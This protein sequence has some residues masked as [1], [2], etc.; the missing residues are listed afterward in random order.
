[1]RAAAR[2]GL[3]LWTLYMLSFGGGPHSP[4]EIG[5]LGTTASLVRRGSFDANEL[6]WMIPAAGDRSDAQVE[7]GPSGDVWSVRGPTVPLQMAPWHALALWLPWLDV[8]FTTLLSSSLVTAATG[9]LLVLLGRRAGLSE[10]AAIAG[11]A[12]F[13]VASMAWP[14]A[15]LG[16]GEPAIGLLTVAAALVAPLGPLG[17]AGAG[18]A[19]AG[20]AGAKWSAAALAAPIGLYVV[21][22]RRSWRGAVAFAAGFGIG[23]AA[24]AW[25]NLARFGSALST[26]YEL[27]GREQF[28]T[29]PW[30]GLLGLT[31]SP[32]R[33]LIWFWP[34]AVA[35]ALALPAAWRRAPWLVALAVAVLGVTVATFAGWRMWWGGNAWGPR[36]LVPAL[37]LLALVLPL[38]WSGLGRAARV[39]A[40]GLVAASAL[41]QVPGVLF[42]FN[43]FER[44][45]RGPLPDFP[46]AGGL[47]DARA[48]QI[49][50]QARRLVDGWPCSVDL[51]WVKCGAVDWALAA[52]LVGALALAGMALGG[53]PPA[54][55]GRG[56]VAPHPG[57]RPH[58]S[59]LPTGEGTQAGR[60][61]RF[62]A[63]TRSRGARG[64]LDAVAGLGAV[65]ALALLLGRGPAAPGGSMAELLEAA[66]AR[67]AAARPGDG[68]IVLAS[69]AVPA[70]W[71]RDRWRGAVYGLNRDDVPRL[72]EAERMLTLAA[73]RHARL[74]LI[75]ADVPRDEA[76]NGVDRW[77]DGHAFPVEER[78]IGAARLRLL[79]TGPTERRAPAPSE[80]L[81]RFAGEGVELAGA[82]LLDDRVSARDPARVELAWRLAPG[83]AEGVSVFVHLYADGRLVGQADAPLARSLPHGAAAATY[84][85]VGYGRYA[86]RLAEGAAG[87]LSLEV[88]LYRAATGERLAALR[89]ER[90]RFEADRVPV[91]RLSA[92]AGRRARRR[93][94]APSRRARARPR[95]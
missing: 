18:L 46:R 41:V 20:A 95:R 29:D 84:R 47:L 85:G 5:Q 10:R 77:L 63:S 60:D 19:V 76:L 87:E 86:P 82:W 3:L 58:P 39:A 67:D 1:V 6:F 78:A 36:F 56:V 90:A 68:L 34:A 15:R 7:I 42:D 30:Y 32:Y 23:M 88:G 45:L 72:P 52:A 65:G 57:G 9:A 79:L 89:P 50:D 28:S 61:V 11:G 26:G 74:W 70:L 14:Y 55:G 51:V 33:G 83:A 75:A 93:P 40:A 24:L 21:L 91:G 25:H 49:V 69:P 31:L 8:T 37:P 43:V 94:G 71:S 12:I 2:V 13:G 38:G 64:W 48:G 59:P 81:A 62:V 27:A 4:D 53:W 80:L 22:P 66:R 44:E 92:A 17:A 54:L 73:G 16:F 35:V